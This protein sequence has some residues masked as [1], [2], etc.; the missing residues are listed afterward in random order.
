MTA[1]S[2]SKRARV[3]VY[4]LLMSDQPVTI[5]MRENGPYLVRGP[6]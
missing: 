4:T 2:M 6:V 3:L 5:T 1:Q